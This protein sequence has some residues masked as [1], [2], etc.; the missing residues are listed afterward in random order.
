MRVL[1]ER[2]VESYREVLR[3]KREEKSFGPQMNTD[4]R[5]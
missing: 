5:G 2:L 3:E 4:E 1:T